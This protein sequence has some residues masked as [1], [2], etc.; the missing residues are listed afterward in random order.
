MLRPIPQ[1]LRIRHAL[2]LHYRECGSIISSSRR[3]L[4]DNRYCFKISCPKQVLITAV[5]TKFSTKGDQ[6][7]IGYKIRCPG[8]TLE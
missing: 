4:R 6:L 2:L 8:E 1:K 3:A 7:K 5:Y